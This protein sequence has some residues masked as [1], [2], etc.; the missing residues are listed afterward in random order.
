MANRYANKLGI[1]LSK[2]VVYK[3]FSDEVNISNYA[4][5]SIKTLFEAEIIKGNDNNQFKPKDE[6][7]RAEVA[8]IIYNLIG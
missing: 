3:S 6:T 4:L 5:D 7:T 8:V 1:E 2:S